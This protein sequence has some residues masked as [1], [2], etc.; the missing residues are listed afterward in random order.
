[1]KIIG[2]QHDIVWENKLANFD[3]VRL[4]LDRTGVEPGSLIALPEMFSTGYDMDV[5]KICEND[6]GE[7]ELFLR[8][9]A[10]QYRST[11]VGGL[12]TR[13]TGDRGY[14]QSFAAGPDGEE[15]VRYAKMHPFTYARENEHYEPG[16]GPVIFAWREFT[17]APLVCYDLRFPE[18]FRHCVQLGANLFLV[19]ANWPK[20]REEHWVT[21]LKARAIENQAYV[22]GVNRCGHDPKL[23]Y[24]GRSLVFDPRGAMMADAGWD[25][26]GVVVAVPD[27]PALEAYRQEFPALRDMR[28]MYRFR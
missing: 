20:P 2:V 11:V 15:I 14:N 24:F 27:F 18:L 12:V 6:A 4:L 17:V 21:L 3:R 9:T 23:E 19:I 10:K 22:M 7:T 13:M 1:M 8:D 28:D 16:Q 26:E 5:N 25:V